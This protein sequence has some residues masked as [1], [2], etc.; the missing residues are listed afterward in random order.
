MTRRECLQRAALLP[1]VGCLVAP[2]LSLAA[3]APAH[4]KPKRVAAVV[5]VYFYN[6]H[7]DVLLGK[8]MEGWK[9]DGGPGPALEL[10][11]VY[12]DQFPAGDI[13][14]AA[15][16]KR[17]VP[18]FDTIEKAITVGGS[19]IP[20]DGVLSIGEHGD[21]PLNEIGQ[22]LYPRRRFFEEI[23]N[24]FEKYGKVV[25]VFND[26]H[27]GPLWTDA[28]WMYDRAREL[29]VPFMAGSS[30]P[31][32]YRLQEHPLP[33]GTEI[34]AAVGIGFSG[35]EIYGFHALEFLQ[36]HLERRQRAETGVKS[37]Q[38]LEGTEMWKAV[39]SGVVSKEA[40]EVAFAAVPKSGTPD[41]RTDEKAAMFLIEYNDGLRAAI[42][43]L[44][45]VGGTSVGLKIKGQPQPTALSFDERTVPRH[46]HFACLLKS[47]E[48]MIHTGR[49]SYP[50]E[51]TLLTSGILDRVLNSKHQGGKQLQT[52]ELAISYQPVDY[53]YA[54]HIDLLADPSK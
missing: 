42:F 39:D 38:F 52:P 25:P 8:I 15:C 17:G 47:I 50:V 27:L 11:G 20:V 7:A 48:R 16:A 4:V 36:W 54:P 51:R 12:I 44:S 13:G 14:R 18:I 35:L 29:Q 24:T 46:P 31:V 41:P 6:S 30:M 10:A 9:Q 40:F 45:C 23:T 49:P 28:R 32:G 26:K 33:M 53:P 2:T 43:M 21:Y 19:S 22:Q 37:V 1:L 34:E 5:T 3:P